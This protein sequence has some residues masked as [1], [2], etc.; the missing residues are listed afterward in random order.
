MRT[1]LIAGASGLVGSRCLARLLAEPAYDRVIALV[2]RPM[3]Q[4]DPRL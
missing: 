4:T 3:P 2:R 1:A